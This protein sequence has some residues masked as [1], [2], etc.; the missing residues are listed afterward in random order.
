MY[1]HSYM[2]IYVIYRVPLI[3]WKLNWAKMATQTIQM[4]TATTTIRTM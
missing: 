3:S 4:T 2:S 1:L